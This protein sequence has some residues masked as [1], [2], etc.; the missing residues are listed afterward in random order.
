MPVQVNG[1]LRDKIIVPIGAPEADIRAA[2]LASEKA[3]QFMEGKPVK[4]VIIVPRRLVN[5]VV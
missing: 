3:R 4:K 2:A 5:I 1:K